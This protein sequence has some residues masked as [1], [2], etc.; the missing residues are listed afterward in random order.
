[1]VDKHE[2]KYV[3]I[4]KGLLVVMFTIIFTSWLAISTFVETITSTTGG[5]ISFTGF[6]YFVTIL[7]IMF[8]P[9]WA[10]ILVHKMVAR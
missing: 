5:V 2:E 3:H 10:S 9:L 7:I 6:G 8:S 4:S 1:M